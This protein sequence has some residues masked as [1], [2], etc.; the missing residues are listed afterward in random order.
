METIVVPAASQAQKKIQDF[1]S[2][3]DPKATTCP[4]KDVLHSLTDK[5]STLVV[6][7]LGAAGTLR[8]SELK[9]RVFGISQKMLTVTLKNLEASGLLTRTVYP[10]VPPRVEYTLTPVGLQFLGHLTVMID[11]ACANSAVVLKNRKK[12]ARKA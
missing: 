9:T 1:F 10:Q 8:F 2:Q 3:Q 5:W 4:V 11:W 6:M 12:S 7:N